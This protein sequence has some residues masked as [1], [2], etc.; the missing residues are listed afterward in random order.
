M[1]GLTNNVTLDQRKRQMALAGAT[2]LVVV[3]LLVLTPLYQWIKIAATPLDQPDRCVIYPKIAPKHSA[4][5]N[6]T[7]EGILHDASFRKHAVRKLSGA[8]QVDTQIGD[9]LPP[10]DDKKYWGKFKDFHKYLEQAFPAVYSALS[11]DTVN[12]YGLLYTWPGSDKSLKPVLL[13]AHQ[14]V[15]PVQQATLDQWKYPPFSGHYDGEFIYGRGTLDCK[16]QVIAIL[17]SL[18]I[19]IERGYKPKRTILVSFGFDEESSGYHGAAYLAKEIE[20]RYGK[21][22]L[23]AIIDEGSAIL[24]DPLSGQIVAAPA[25]GEKGYVDIHTS[26]FTKGGH[27]SI[28]PPHTSIGIMA[29]LEV[30]IEKD[31]YEPILTDANPFLHQLECAA[32]HGTHLSR[33]ERKTILRAAFDKYAN[34]KVIKSLHGTPGQYLVQTSQ[35]LDIIK[36]GEK[37][38]ALPEHTKL[39]TNHRVAIG[40]SVKEVTHHFV[41]RVVEV[42]KRHDLEVH[43][44]GKQVLKG[45]KGVFNITTSGALPAAPKSP[46]NNT[47]WKVLAGVN[48]H[49]LEDFGVFPK[50]DYKV[51]TVP[52]IMTGNTDTRHYWNLTKNIYRFSPLVMHPDTFSR[53]HSVDERVKVDDHLLMIA[54]FHEYL[55]VVTDNFKIDE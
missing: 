42:A 14:D 26:L 12:T 27:A 32:V 13:M 49:V 34:D 6:A 11:V 16:G 43:A 37:A 54:W 39:V 8:V 48:R 5:D 7:V 9:Q 29:E 1:F 53:I 28:P 46:T 47:S 4:K 31:P 17:Q 44:Y 41:K 22:S 55:S 50:I 25:T 24:N 45:S 35:A 36:G 15:V 51:M 30:A 33:T 18:S 23:F 38:N 19:L 2:V 20:R 10:V 52:S 21:D 40:Q 3:A